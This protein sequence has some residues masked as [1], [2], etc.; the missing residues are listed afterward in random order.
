[1]KTPEQ[2]KAINDRVA[3][4][5]TQKKNLSLELEEFKRQLNLRKKTIV[6]ELNALKKK[7]HYRK[8][9]EQHYGL[10]DYSTS[11]AVQLFGKREKDLTPE[12]RREYNKLM[13]REYRNKRRK[14]NE[15]TRHTEN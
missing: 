7:V 15:T 1:M 2:W 4:L 5:E 12:E 6:T 13:M 3:E 8:F 11:P 9:Y 10:K 14:Q